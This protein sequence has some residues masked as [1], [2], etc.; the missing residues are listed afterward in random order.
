MRINSQIP[1]CV[2]DGL[3]ALMIASAKGHHEVMRLLLDKGADPDIQQVV[4]ECQS[5][6]RTRDVW[7]FVY[8]SGLAAPLTVPST[9]RM[10]GQL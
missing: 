3:T 8:L 4:S 2:R 10:A 9:C 7:I 6:L 1:C 5:V